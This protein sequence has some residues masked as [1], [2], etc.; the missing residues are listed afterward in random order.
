MRS[1]MNGSTCENANMASMPLR[2]YDT[3]VAVTAVNRR[4]SMEDMVRS[5][6]NTSITKRMPAM[7]A[8]KMPA[9][10]PAAPH[11]TRIIKLRCSSRKK[12]P[13]F[14]PMADPVST[15]GASAPTDPPKPMVIELAIR[16]V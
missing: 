10:A 15:I 11:P 14:D 8:L 16:E 4:G 3:V 5:S 13:R 6:S 2:M 9:M 7:G 12:L 1:S